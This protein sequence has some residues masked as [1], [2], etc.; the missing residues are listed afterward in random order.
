MFSRVDVELRLDCRT[1]SFIRSCESCDIVD[2]FYVVDV[3]SD[4][5]VF[6]ESRSIHPDLPFFNNA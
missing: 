5:N 1:Q 6:R 3:I 4:R 2:Y